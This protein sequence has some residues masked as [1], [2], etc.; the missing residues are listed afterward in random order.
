RGLRTDLAQAKAS[1]T[2]TKANA[3]QSEADGKANTATQIENSEVLDRAAA[4]PHHR[5]RPLLVHV[6]F[7]FVPGLAPG[8]GIGIVRGLAYAR[9]S[10]AACAGATMWH[11]PS[12]PPSSSASVP[13]GCAGGCPA[14]AGSRPAGHLAYGVSPRTCAPPC[15]KTPDTR[16]PWLWL[17]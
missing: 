15:Q 6:A 8:L 14:G 2:A 17:P 4:L 13:C 10:P 9:G 1:L 5:L 3:A 11:T 16:T 12:A 7:G